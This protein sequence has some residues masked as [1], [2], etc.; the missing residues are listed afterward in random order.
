MSDARSYTTAFKADTSNF[1][2]GTEEMVKKLTELNKALVGNQAKQ[3][4]ANQ[5]ISAAQKELK[6]M[7]QTIGPLTLKQTEH[8][9]SLNNSIEQE[10]LKLAQLKTEQTGIR[11]AISATS[12]AVAKSSEQWTVAK[13]T[14]ANL[15][16]GGIALV[17]QK[18]LQLA[19]NVLQ[20]GEQFTK[21]MS[22]VI[23]ISGAT[24]EEAELLEQAARKAGSTTK[25]TAAESA[26]ALKYMSLAGW[27]TEQS[28]SALPGVLNLA[29]VGG[30]DLATAS[31]MVTDY[32]AAF[33]LQ[34]KDST[35]MV[36]LMTYAQNNSN[37][38][39]VQLGESYQNSAANMHAAGQSI[40]TTTALLE[41]MANQGVKGSEAG[42]KLAAV[43]RDRTSKMTEGKIQIGDVSVA[44]E[45]AKGNFRD[46]TDIL[47]DIEKA[48]YGLGNAQKS[49]ALQS[50]FSARSIQSINLILNDG[51]QNISQYEEAL[52][53][54][55][56]SASKAAQTMGDNLSGDIKRMNSAFSE[57]SLKIY[58]DAET[59]L[60][61][62]VQLITKQGVPATQNLI[63]NLDKIVPVV[64]AG[65]S[66]MAAYKS[67]LAILSIVKGIQ[68][69]IAGLTAAKAAETVVTQTN[70]VATAA[71]T[72]V[73]E[74]DTAAKEEATVATG[75]LNTVMAANPVGLV[76]AGISALVSILISYL[77]IS[78]QA[79]GSTKE[80]N[81]EHINYLE[82]LEKSEEAT[83][84]KQSDTENEIQVLKNLGSQYEA[85]RSQ[86]SLTSAEQTKL[87]TIA[88]Q[89]AQTMGVGIDTLKDTSGKY[90][91]LSGDIDT[92][93]DKLREKIKRESV[94]DNKKPAYSA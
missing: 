80:L 40:E 54:A 89:I 51:S 86:T 64:I 81:E 21:S 15:A 57:L 55:S 31:S 12:Q 13:A 71:D 29:A 20:T 78:K 66:A 56:G 82:T 92:Y 42:T 70:T 43:F 67:S 87:D 68:E 93:C 63:Q 38:T 62:I 47:A 2:K 26:Q 8:I 90:K 34:A 44:V 35:Y 14:L 53:G 7:A 1:K 46:F 65:A 16:S 32:L 72:V 77:A 52:K 25:F 19:R 76:V 17:S 91:E 79:S 28:L 58:D 73:T 45:D 60:R 18:L 61:D 41:A 83:K 39:A 3:K 4:E 36:D 30:T 94:Q 88:S 59:P 24:K 50:T 27:D 37:L 6:T 23:A 85:L 10:R 49:Q 74:A 33:G 75:A 11:Q 22:E 5:T 69:G 9:K 48:T 84:T